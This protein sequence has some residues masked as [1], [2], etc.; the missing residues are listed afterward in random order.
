MNIICILFPIYSAV[1]LLRITR[2]LHFYPSTGTW[3]QVWLQWIHF[4]FF[5]R[6]F[7]SVPSDFYLTC[8]LMS[9]LAIIFFL[10]LTKSTE[11]LASLSFIL[12]M[13]KLVF[14]LLTVLGLLPLPGEEE[15]VP[16]LL[17][18]QQIFYLQWLQTCPPIS[19][20]CTW[21]FHPP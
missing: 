1:L 2:C 4:I 21:N 13:L 3:Y 11:A 19:G 17:Q 14:S 9:L 15:P 7:L 20:G 6:T 8:L 16:G 12:F 10:S 5:P 18:P